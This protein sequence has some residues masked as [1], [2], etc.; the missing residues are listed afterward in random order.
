MSTIVNIRL[1]DQSHKRYSALATDAGLGLSTYLRKRLE[2][3]DDV[4]RQLAE[5]RLAIA[6][7]RHGDGETS[8]PQIEE[9]LDR[10]IAL[11]QG[12]QQPANP[13]VAAAMDPAML[14]ECLLLLRFVSSPENRAKA[15]GELA[16]HGL[17]F[18]TPPPP[19]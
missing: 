5:L 19:I 18:W 12:G 4:A 15:H 7:L 3:G 10:M 1:S 11:L 17:K 14:L 9:K 2:E 13:A 16:R 6:A 8:T